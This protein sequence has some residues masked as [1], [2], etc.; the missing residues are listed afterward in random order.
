V[1]FIRSGFGDEV[2][3]RTRVA[4]VFGREVR[5][6]H[7]ELLHRVERRGR[8]RAGVALVVVVVAVEDVAG[9]ERAQPV[10]GRCARLVD[11]TRLEQD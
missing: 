9:R 5:R 1:G 3:L 8:G 6:Q 4:T 11:D 10:R 2:E 7:P